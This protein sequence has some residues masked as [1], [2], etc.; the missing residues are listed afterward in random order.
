MYLRGL[1]EGGGNI[2]P[3]WFVVEL[4]TAALA[5]FGIG[6]SFC[7]EI[8]YCFGFTLVFCNLV[9]HA[10]V[11]FVDCVYCHLEAGDVVALSTAAANTAA[12]SI[13]VPCFAILS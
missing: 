10:L 3:L 5:L 2:P 6:F 12:E 11:D 4:Y 1:K 13:N 8:F 7:S 9:C